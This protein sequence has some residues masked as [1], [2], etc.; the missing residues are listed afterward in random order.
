MSAGSAWVHGRDWPYTLGM[1]LVT[2][3]ALLAPPDIL[4][5]NPTLNA[6]TNAIAS[7]L[8]FV[9]LYAH[10]S[11]WPQLTKATLALAMALIPAVL[12]F[13]LWG[14]MRALNVKRITSSRFV[15]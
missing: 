9:D 8:P 12:P 13:T 7:V 4:D 5:R 6:L 10:I 11:P 3:F 15:R 2:L 1:A 14:Q